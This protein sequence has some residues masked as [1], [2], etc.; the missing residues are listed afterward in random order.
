MQSLTKQTLRIFWQHSKPYKLQ[1]IIIALGLIAVL[2]TDIAQPF[3]YRALV[4]YVSEADTISI[5]YPLKMV[6]YI[7]LMALLY[8]IGW[9]GIIMATNVFQ[10][11]AKRDLYQK[12]Y[13]YV[14]G[15]S[16]DFFNNNFVGGLVSKI[17]RYDRAYE[18]IADEIIFGAGR[19]AL[20]ML[21]IFIS[22]AYQI[23]VA[24]FILGGWIIMYLIIT[25][26]L[27]KYRFTYDLAASQQ[28]T[29]ATGHLADTITNSSTVKLFATELKERALFKDITHEQYLRRR[30]S[31]DISNY[32][33]MFQG[34]MMIILEFSLLYV[35]LRLW[36]AGN[37]TVG[38][39]VLL[40]SFMLSVFQ[41]LWNI[42]RNMRQLYQGMADANEMT[43]ILQ[44]PYE[45]H[46]RPNSQK[47]SINH[48][49]VDFNNITFTYKNNSTI[50][51]K[52]NLSIEAGERVALVGPSGGGKSTIV[53]LLFRFYDVSNGKIEI[54][55]QD[56]AQ[57]TQAS[58]REQISLVPQD[59]I[60]FHRSIL[61]N[62]RY[63]KPKATLKEVIAAAKAAHC[64]EFINLLPQRYETMVGERG[65]KLS[66]GER[67]R[68]AIARAI[69]KN[70]PILVLDEAT[71]SLDSES[72]SLI[73]DALQT[74]MKGKTTIV[75]AHRLST[76]MAMDRIVVI[77][78]GKIAEQGK[79]EELLKAQAGKY[80]K[81][82]HIQAGSFATTE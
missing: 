10:G 33:D 57:A 81:L 11:K 12:C 27:N 56:I 32:I 65:V 13:N 75:I 77:E 54:D 78:N 71:S 47:I 51:K 20:L 49:A 30:K 61:E 22:L 4:N 82:W 67:Q 6:I 41:H 73:Q 28:D 2:I 17:G 29:V 31:W 76:I 39:F 1:I 70:A 19:T 79:H 60:L 58:L 42:G 64:H 18:T 50:F 55:G 63:A 68:V 35:A 74:L 44:T 23:P 5:A 59:P 26:K 80:Q 40:Q 25:L 37:I 69:L 53:K 34:G 24:A 46:D 14:M 38:D 15:H 16:T 3:L 21:F 45:V 8:N 36:Q 48:G 62:I 9:R 7:F 52:F 66:G 72:E 43:E